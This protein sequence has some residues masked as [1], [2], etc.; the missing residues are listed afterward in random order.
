MGNRARLYRHLYFFG[1]DRKK[2]LSVLEE[3]YVILIE[4]MEEFLSSLKPGSNLTIVPD[5]ILKQVRFSLY[6]NRSMEENL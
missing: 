5:D 4:P 3:L 6:V 2:S 1:L